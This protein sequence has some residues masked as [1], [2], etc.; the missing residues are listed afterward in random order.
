MEVAEAAGASVARV[1]GV[2]AA[3]RASGAAPTAALP[4]AAGLPGVTAAAKATL[5]DIWA[6]ESEV[7]R[8]GKILSR[9]TK[10]A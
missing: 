3:A 1:S 9:G 6:R 7:A 2:I 5:G 8:K 10:I 4:G